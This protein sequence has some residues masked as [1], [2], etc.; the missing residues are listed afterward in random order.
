M[1]FYSTRGGACVTASQAVLWGLAADGGLYVPSMFPQFS[2]E[3]ISSFCQMS[4]QQIA[5][6]V[7]RGFLED[8]SISEIE[9]SVNA[10]YTS[11]AFDDPAIAPVR[12]LDGNVYVLELFHGPT[13]AFKDIALKLLPYLV[14]LAA[15]KN[16][17]KREISILVATS[18]DTGKA[19]LEGFKDVPGTS[20]TVFYPAHGVSALQQLQMTTTT[21]ANTHVIGVNGNFDDA[22][23]G[24]KRL[25]SSSEFHEKMNAAGRLPSS[26]NS[27]NFGRL[28]PQVAYYFSTYAALVNN[29]A[30]RL[31]QPLNFAV[32][33]GNFGDIL[34]GYYAKRMGLPIGRLICASNRNNVL[35]DFFTDGIYYTHRT[36]FQTMSPSM[37]ILISS[38]LER[39]LYECAD[40]DGRIVKSWMELLAD[41]GSFSIGAQRL[42]ELQKT[43]SAGFAD[44]VMTA[45]EIRRVFERTGYLMDPHTA[46]ASYVLNE[47]R[48]KSEDRSPTVIV[49]TASPYK[50]S[51]DVLA[52]LCGKEA[53]AG[54]DAFACAEELQAKTGV[55][56]PRQIAELR[57]LPVLHRS[58]CEKNGME[59]ALFSELK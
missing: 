38:N 34:A 17:E 45:G 5:Q 44:D 16:E 26:A 13:L 24:V 59:A 10:A 57:T 3:K 49:S 37:D 25:F 50:F 40:R 35:S 32:P 33:T 42:A 47:Y 19:A 7:L 27:I 36:F 54:L 8:Y 30:V 46:V 9:E 53:T 21:G 41:C 22:Q 20:C 29:G 43:F 2:E 14:R 23:T 51:E 6:R 52:S 48:E 39:L 28:A 12:R 58:V 4:Y 31:G 1:S 18:G 56:V 55:P 15:Q 11:P